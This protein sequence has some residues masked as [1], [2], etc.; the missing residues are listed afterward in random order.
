MNG[1]YLGIGG[2][3]GNRSKYLEQ[4]RLLISNELGTIIKTSTIYQTAAWGKTNQQD[5]Y[6]QVLF[7]K[8]PLSPTESIKKCLVIETALGRERSNKWDSR[9]IDIDILFYN[10]EIINSKNLQVPHPYLHERNFVLVPLHE[11]APHFIHPVFR[12]KILTLLKQSPD[13]LAVK[14]VN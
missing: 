7:V 9:T 12:K 14:K 3:K 8:S 2:N 6:N 13:Q 4:A 10:H 1:I 5:F 11:I